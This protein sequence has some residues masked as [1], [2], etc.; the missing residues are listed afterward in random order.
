MPSLAE[1]PFELEELIA[2]NLLA[3][4]EFDDALQVVLRELQD[5]GRVGYYEFIFSD[6][7]AGSVQ[8]AYLTSYLVTEGRAELEL[9]PLEE[10]VFISPR[11]SDGTAD[12]RLS[13]SRS[14]PLAVSYVDWSAWKKQPKNHEREQSGS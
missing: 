7:F 5:R 11:E 2:L 6:T 10:S 1:A 9:N 4:Q 3:G 13:V 12:T 8:R 14:I